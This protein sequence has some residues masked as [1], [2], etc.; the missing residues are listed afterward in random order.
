MIKFLKKCRNVIIS[1]IC[2]KLDEQKVQNE[3]ILRLLVNDEQS[4]NNVSENGFISENEVKCAYKMLLKREPEQ[5]AIVAWQ[6]SNRTITD[7]REEIWKSEEFQIMIKKHLASTS[8]GNIWRIVDYPNRDGFKWV[9]RDLAWDPIS[10]RIFS[11]QPFEEADMLIK[12]LSDLEPE[13]EI[14]DIGANLGVF[15][16]HLAQK[17][18]KVYSIE[19]SANNAECL[20]MTSRLNDFDVT[21]CEWGAF[22]RTGSIYFVQRGPWGEIHLNK[23]EDSEE[24]KCFALDDYEQTDLRNAKIKFIKMDIEGSEATVIRGAKKFLADMKYPPIFSERNNLSLLSHGD[25]R[26]SY[27]AAFLA[28]GYKP[29]VLEDNVLLRF[30]PDILSEKLSCDYIFLNDNNPFLHDRV[31]GDYKP[32]RMEKEIIDAIIAHDIGDIEYVLG[33]TANL[34]DSK[35]FEYPEVR[36]W[37]DKVKE[38][39]KDSDDYHVKYLYK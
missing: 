37:N 3:R 15:T 33:Q 30:N 39:Y 1:P 21:V 14:L 35:Y 11:C 7:L 10:Q 12:F 27:F 19:A 8:S 24:I 9:L 29:Y 34:K 26:E 20:R 25:T 38:Y 31:A 23:T 5:E 13:A 4:W 32:K 28:A 36:A 16:F 6:F 22:E 18:H 2:Q 17:G